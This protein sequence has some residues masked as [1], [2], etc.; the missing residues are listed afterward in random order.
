VL[1]FGPEPL[2]TLFQKI[3]KDSLPMLPL[4][5]VLAQQ[6]KPGFHLTLMRLPLLEQALARHRPGLPLYVVHPVPPAG[7]APRILHYVKEKGWVTLEE[8]PGAFDPKRDIV[9]LRLYRGYLADKVFN[10]PL[11]TEDDYLSSIG[12]L[13]ELLPEDLATA[14]R[15]TLY[16]RPA[17][18]L[19]MSM[20]T[21]DHRHVLRCLMGRGLHPRSVVLLEPGS[22]EADSWRKGRSL[23]RGTSV[24]VV[25]VAFA[26][27]T[28]LIAPAAPGGPP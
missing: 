2:S 20:L 14:L 25:P 13:E 9:V 4:V 7:D 6:L 28:Q 12:D 18:L 27:L 5:E 26:E 16:E 10:E 21:W 8:M 15:S 11:L 23:L 24:H 22:A 19:G 3:F 1:Q 17:L